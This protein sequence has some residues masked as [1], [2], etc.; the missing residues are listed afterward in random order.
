MRS[1]KG[2]SRY[3]NNYMR[4]PLTL[5][6]FSCLAL[7]SMAQPNNRQLID[8]VVAVVGN[9]IILSSDVEAQYNQYLESGQPVSDETRC[10]LFEELL[11]QELLLNQAKLDSVDVPEEQVQGEIDRRLNFFIQQIGSEEKLEEF[12][13]K[14]IIE[15]KAEFHDLIR[16]QLLVQ[17]MQSKI[18]ENVSITPGGVRDY[19]NRFPADSLPYVDSEV[20]VAQIVA[21]PQVSR[22]A[23]QRELTYITELRERILAGEDFATLA[24]LYSEDPGSA[25][26]G[27][28]LGFVSRQMLVPEFARVA[29][30]IE[31]GQIS[32]VVESDFGFHILELIERSGELVNVRHILRIPDVAPQD[33]FK[34]KNRLDS[35]TNLINTVDTLSFELAAQ[36]FSDDDET[37]NNGGKMINPQTGSTR[38]A[39]DEMGQ[40][41]PSLFYVIDK[42]KVGQISKPTQ[43]QMADGSQVYRIVKLLNRSKPHKAN[44]S[45]DYQMIQNYA[46]NEKKQEAIDAWIVK[47]IPKTYVRIEEEYKSCKFD[48]QWLN[49]Q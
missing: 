26:N 18:T 21:K 33:F 24:I 35:I 38:L 31:K 2:N 1:K 40:V 3:W 13:N 28:E 20:E 49:A 4:T 9:D 17:T 16:D 37:K 25:P 43:A 19:F 27:G 14:S 39:V 34:A 22:A 48:Y 6:L 12:Y 47:T 5:I 44:L 36:L 10:I 15:I 41:D 29:F 45:D 46:L 11:Y 7:A 8:K 32:E 30:S 23:R 42:L